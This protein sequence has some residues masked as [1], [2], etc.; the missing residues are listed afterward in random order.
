MPPAI[1]HTVFTCRRVFCWRHN[2]QNTHY[3]K[4]AHT[5]KCNRII[6]VWGYLHVSGIKPIQY[7]RNGVTMP[8]KCLT[9]HF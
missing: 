4:K 7:R 6:A 8:R 1:R 2:H 5:G 9:A 3:R